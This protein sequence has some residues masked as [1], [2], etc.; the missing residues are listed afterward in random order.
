MLKKPMAMR[1]NTRSDVET[2]ATIN[3]ALTSMLGPGTGAF[4]ALV[5]LVLVTATGVWVIVVATGALVE[6]GELKGSSP[7]LVLLRGVLGGLDRVLLEGLITVLLGDP[8]KRLLEG[9]GGGG[10]VGGGEGGGLGGGGNGGQGSGSVSR[11]VV[12]RTNEV[13][14]VH[15]AK[16]AKAI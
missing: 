13:L 5:W 11:K 15:S 10:G 9:L 16:I 14:I 3:T 7:L 6:G 4:G 12:F 2:D 1:T 8:I